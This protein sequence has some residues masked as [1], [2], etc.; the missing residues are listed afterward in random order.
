M[1]KSAIVSQRL[2]E[3]KGARSK[4]L[5]N[6]LA[7][8]A[9][10]HG[11][12]FL[13]SLGILTLCAMISKLSF[14]VYMR[15]LVLLFPGAII[16]LL[17]SLIFR[18]AWKNSDESLLCKIFGRQPKGFYDIVRGLRTLLALGKIRRIDD[19]DFEH[20]LKDIA[21]DRVPTLV[22]GSLAGPSFLGCLAILDDI[23]MVDDGVIDQIVLSSRLLGQLFPKN[24][25]PRDQA[26]L[27]I[28]RPPSEIPVL[29]SVPRMTQDLLRTV[30]NNSHP[31][32]LIKTQRSK[33]CGHQQRSESCS[34][35]AGQL[36]QGCRWGQ[37]SCPLCAT[38]YPALAD[39][40][41]ERS[42]FSRGNEKSR[43][44]SLQG[45]EIT[46]YYYKFKFS[47]SARQRLQNKFNALKQM[48]ESSLAHLF[49]DA[50]LDFDVAYV[51]HTPGKSLF[52]RCQ[53]ASKTQYVPLS[54]ILYTL[55]GILSNLKKLYLAGFQPPQIAAQAVYR[56]REI[57][58]LVVNPEVYCEGMTGR[59]IRAQLQPDLFLANAPNERDQL[60]GAIESIEVW[61]IGIFLYHCL[62]GQK[63]IERYTQLDLRETPRLEEKRP[64][65]PGSVLRLYDE[66]LAENPE[67]R[68]RLDS[69]MKRID[70]IIEEQSLPVND[71][72]TRRMKF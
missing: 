38:R 45:H 20:I 13:L 25:T 59:P 33:F 24:P 18:A 37:K 9:R 50:V 69:V 11:V 34:S 21:Q 64:D 44:R 72:R 32:D 63:I 49:Y 26:G 14:N 43:G 19:E 56:Q 8:I 1:T 62:T 53:E 68:P 17:F 35:C 40:I 61:A 58:S 42:V 27:N 31:G 5:G 29:F 41:L 54:P 67:D 28:W 22:D 4:L 47:D 65:L 71:G 66:C 30:S 7:G 51:F 48:T 23:E 70:E 12:M 10:G 16:V 3:L 15:G 55:K 57:E 60:N 2:S 46:A 39:F 6:A 36:C 52:E